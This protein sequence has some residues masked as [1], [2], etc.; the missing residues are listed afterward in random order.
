MKKAVLLS[1]GL[2][3]IAGGAFAQQSIVFQPVVDVNALDAGATAAQLAL[4]QR[5]QENM[6]TNRS[7]NKTTNGATG[8]W[9]SYVDLM[10]GGTGIGTGYFWTI[11][12]DSSFKN[13]TATNVNARQSIFG[14][15]VSFDPTSGA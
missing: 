11:Q 14:F 3:A 9:F 8:A 15:G 13:P 7:S 4:P 10:Y 12:A 2:T 1:L 6:A 5:G